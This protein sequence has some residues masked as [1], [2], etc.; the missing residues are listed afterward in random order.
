MI[1]LNKVKRCLSIMLLLISVSSCTDEISLPGSDAFTGDWISEDYYI[2][3]HVAKQPEYYLTVFSNPE[4]LFNGDRRAEQAGT[5]LQLEGSIVPMI[6]CEGL[7]YRSDTDQ[8]SHCGYLV[9]NRYI[10][11]EE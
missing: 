8:L 2:G 6:P 4:G 5:A 9:F 7:T 3:L 11:E 1:D 10:T